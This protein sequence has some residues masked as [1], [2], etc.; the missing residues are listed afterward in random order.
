LTGIT[1]PNSKIPDSFEQR[2]YP[3]I[4]L[5]LWFDDRS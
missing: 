1:G 3:F 4:H 5:D 2:S